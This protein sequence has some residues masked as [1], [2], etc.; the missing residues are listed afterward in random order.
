MAGR[1]QVCPSKHV[2]GLIALPSSHNHLAQDRVFST[3]DLIFCP[4]HG[5]FSCE[6]V[7][8]THDFDNGSIHHGWSVNYEE[9]MKG[10]RGDKKSSHL[11]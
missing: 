10:K 4:K 7:R 3:I 6:F 5:Q 9:T 11:S 2:C 8:V 1:L